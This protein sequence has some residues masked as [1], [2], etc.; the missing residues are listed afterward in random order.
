MDLQTREALG[1][2]PLTPRYDEAMIFAATQ[3]RTQLRKGSNIPY[4]SHLM[5]VSSLVLEHGGSEQAAIAGLLHDAVE[6]APNGDGPAVLNEIRSRFGDLVADT[7]ESCSDGLDDEGNRSGDWAQRKVPYV[8]KLSTK[9]REA[10]IVTAADK[11]HNARAIAA[12]IMLCGPEFLGVFNACQ[13]QLVWYY[14]E[15]RDRLAGALGDSTIIHPL[16]E[17]VDALVSAIKTDPV[18]SSDLP[19]SCACPPK[20]AKA[21]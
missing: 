15:V 7:V 21:S 8:K 1:C 19:P 11:T 12:D 14:Q 20:P 18:P 5:S 3:H 10:A 4:L 13:H 2:G 6:D 16:R 9:T 17:A